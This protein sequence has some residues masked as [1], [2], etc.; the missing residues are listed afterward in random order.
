MA[1]GHYYSSYPDDLV[2]PFIFVPYGEPERPE[3]AEFKARY[4]GWIA[5][6]ATFI[7]YP[8]EVEQA[9]DEEPR[10]KTRP[11]PPRPV[12][13]PTQ[14]GSGTD[15]N[16]A[17]RAFLA[18]YRG[19]NDPIAL[20]RGNPVMRD[21]LQR[22]VETSDP[23]GDQ[24]SAVSQVEAPPG[25]RLTAQAFPLPLLAPPPL[26]GEGAGSEIDDA[27]RALSD[28]LTRVWR[29]VFANEATE[30]PSSPG[31]ILAP[32]G[33][34]IGTPD[35][36]DQKTRN[37]PGGA[38]AAEELFEKLSKGGTPSKSRYDHGIGVDL[39]GGGFV[40]YRPKSTSGSPAIDVNIPGL[41]TKKLHFP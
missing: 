33:V 28:A 20:L 27:A 38:K 16:G 40:G 25:E 24:G 9:P 30:E 5:I 35:R 37:L 36:K 32:G 22:S 23:A 15:W 29:S 1:A 6:P 26:A 17:M 19:L 8:R 4:P 21:M 34:P 31:D 39:P 14:P 18:S 11:P 10:L 41:G 13:P 7:P 12:P 3:V 2:L